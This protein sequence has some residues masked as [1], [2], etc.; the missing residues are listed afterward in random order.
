MPGGYVCSGSMKHTLDPTNVKD[1]V[2]GKVPVHKLFSKEQRSVY[3]EQAPEGLGLD[4]L[5]ILGPILVLKVKFTPRAL[6]PQARGGT[7][8]LPRQLDDPR[9]LDEMCPVQSV[10]RSRRTP[11]LPD[12]TGRRSVR[13]TGD[14]DEEG[15]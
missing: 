11:E 14:K 12:S 15:A 2:A 1:S 9:A 3:A 7:L 6:C 13:R 5:A 4:N 10:S 8:A